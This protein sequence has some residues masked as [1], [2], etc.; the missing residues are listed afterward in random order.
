[1]IHIR[2]LRLR[3]ITAKHIYGA[4][5]PL[6]TGLNIV[7]AHNTSG[8]STA[9]QAIIY[10][11]GLERSLGPQLS[12]PLP[13]A[14]RERIHR[15]KDDPY[16]PVLQSYV[17]LEMENEKK[18]SLIIRRDVVGGKDPKLVQTWAKGSL[19]GTVDRGE[20]RDFYVHDSG[21]AQRE[22][23]FH[24]FFADF[25]GWNLPIVPRFDGTEGQLYLEAIFPML[26]VEQKRGWSAIQGPFPTFLKIQ[27]VAR[28]VMEFLLDLNAGKIRRQRGELRSAIA[29]ASQQWTDRRQL[30]EEQAQ[31]I[32]RLRGVPMQ[33]SA[34]FALTPEIKLE[35]F[36]QDEWLPISEV[37][38]DTN[39]RI[40]ELEASHFQTTEAVIPELQRRLEA[41]RR[42]VDELSAVLEVVRNELH[43]EQQEQQGLRSR[44]EFLSADLLRNQDALKLKRLGSDLGR[45]AGEHVCPTCHQDV[46]SELLPAV[47]NVGMGLEENIAFVKSQIELYGTALAGAT[48]RVKDFQGRYRSK[49]EQLR[50]RQAELRSLRQAV[51]QPGSTPTRVVIEEIVRLQAFADRISS[52][53][54]TVAI[55]SDEFQKIAQEWSR[56]QDSLKRLPS[57]ELTGSDI[58]K[59]DSFQSSIQ[60]QLEKYGFVSFRPTEIVLSRDNFRPLAVTRGD[61]GEIIEKEIG[62]EISASDGIRL[63]WAY[64]LSLLALSASESTN[65][66]GLVIYDEPGQ[67]E[68]EAHSLYAFLLNSAEQSAGRQV[69]ISTSEPLEPIR[70]M[71][72]SR[73]HIVSFAGF[74]L[75]PITEASSSNRT[76]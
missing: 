28:R 10:A 15:D 47:E 13:Y 23:G 71:V 6:R 25:M 14:M 43:V 46:S 36:R 37:V 72:G 22:D 35:L 4:D 8:K 52:L 68:I 76:G 49:D 65:H 44:L 69:I 56:L 48:E 51:L 61:E 38:S 19:S 58:R 34:E 7:Q 67:Q 3:A 12:I 9:L 40:R 64:Y 27:D 57:D 39:A 53:E 31:R 45:A 30:L 17:E 16:E 62:Y 20:Q 59:I 50:E 26:F 63:K 74:I 70:Q 66:A 73:A 41:V 11:L 24:T 42:A 29:A 55:E 2:H 1:M 60:T 54:E 75:Q 18:K 32:G 33:P 21:A 5:I